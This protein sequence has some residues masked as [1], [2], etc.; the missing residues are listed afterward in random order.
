MSVA[1]PKCGSRFLRESRSR[2]AEKIPWLSSSLRCDDCQ[3]RFVAKTFVISDLKWARCPCCLRMDLNG[4]TGKT[5]DP[6]FVVG[7]KVRLGAHR[8]RCEYCRL[9][10]ASWRPRKEIFTFS[11][12]QKF[13]AGVDLSAPSVKKEKTILKTGP[14]DMLIAPAESHKPETS[15][16]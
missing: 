5:Y 11:R 10:F 8:W 9:N 7:L 15:V 4:W 14:R 2:G 3:T 13:Q 16:P 12:W 1:C 6:P